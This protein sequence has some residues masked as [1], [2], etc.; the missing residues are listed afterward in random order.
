MPRLKAPQ[1]EQLSLLPDIGTLHSVALQQTYSDDITA[2]MDAV[3]TRLRG[4]RVGLRDL[5]GYAYSPAGLNSIRTEQTFSGDG[6][7]MTLDIATWPTHS[8]VQHK[9]SGHMLADWELITQYYAAQ[10]DS[11]DAVKTVQRLVAEII[12]HRAYET[13][14]RPTPAP[15]PLPSLPLRTYLHPAT[16]SPRH[17]R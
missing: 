4:P 3:P 10:C 12:W 7:R 8:H 5:D 1:T 13:T 2:L 14:R 17:W 11:V 16:G 9:Q 6:F 15:K